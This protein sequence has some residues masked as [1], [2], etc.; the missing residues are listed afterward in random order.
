MP[1]LPG[2]GQD[3]GWHYYYPV[4]EVSV[5]GRQRG[6]HSTEFH[7]EVAM[8]W[9]DGVQHNKSE[10]RWREYDLRLLREEKVKRPGDTRIVFYLAR[11]Y[12]QVSL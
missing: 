8:E 9:I 10:V 1:P 3:D 5:L 12:M 7:K 6:G 2:Q 4:H 11:T